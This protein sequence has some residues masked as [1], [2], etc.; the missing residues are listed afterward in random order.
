[1]PLGVDAS[2]LMSGWMAAVSDD[3]YLTV[4]TGEHSKVARRITVPFIGS[5]YA[6]SF[7]AGS[8]TDW[9]S[10]PVSTADAI[11]ACREQARDIA[12]DAMDRS[13][14]DERNAV[15][16]AFY[17][18]ASSVEYA[19]SDT[20]HGNDMYGALV[21][22]RSQCW[23]MATALKAVLDDMGIPCLVVTGTFNGSEHAWNMVRLGGT[24]L[25]CDVTA[26][27]AEWH[28]NAAT[29]SGLSYD[30]RYGGKAPGAD[31]LLTRCLF[32][33]DR[34]DVLGY[35]LDPLSRRVLGK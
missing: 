15:R 24:W 16:R 26:G 11:E 30:D 31:K 1:M 4:I 12:D 19:D 32:P 10:S 34:L 3:P 18:L 22:G 6:M 9:E 25:A 14:S 5:R 20:G 7:P 35:D 28:D 2:E 17:A 21:E 23:G 29:Y 33:S 13:A 8:M 27:A